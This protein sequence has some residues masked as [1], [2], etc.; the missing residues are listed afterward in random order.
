MG[1]TL[2][3]PKPSPIERAIRKFGAYFEERGLGPSD[4]PAAIIAHE[5]L[6]MMMASAAWAV[7]FLSILNFVLVLFLVTINA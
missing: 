1:A 3:D 2:Q 5:V 6:G 4:L 7:G